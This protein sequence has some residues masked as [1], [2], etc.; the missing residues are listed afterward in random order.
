M[1]HFNAIVAGLAFAC[2]FAIDTGYA[3]T[4]AQ[5]KYTSGSGWSLSYYVSPREGLVVEDAMFSGL[6]VAKKMSVPYVVV[7]PLENIVNL[8]PATLNKG[9]LK[10]TTFGEMLVIEA[11]Y[12]VNPSI[13]IS[14]RYEFHAISKGCEPTAKLSCGRFKPLL[15]YTYSGVVK[16]NEPVITSIQRLHLQPSNGSSSIVGVFHDCAIPG[17]I[18]GCN[19]K[20]VVPL[21]KNPLESEAWFPMISRGRAINTDYGLTAD[22]Y[23]HATEGTIG[24]PSLNWSLSDPYEPG[25][26]ECLHIHWRWGSTAGSIA[27]PPFQDPIG[28]PIIPSGSDQSASIYIVKDT[29]QAVADIPSLVNGQ[30]L[31]GSMPV[32]FYKATGYQK[33]D[34]FF[35]HGGFITTGTGISPG[36]TEAPAAPTIRIITPQ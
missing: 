9:S 10:E 7:H 15:K 35:F 12:S 19:L 6:P 20:G 28:Q 23:H 17:E 31:S 4:N 22:N 16:P 8:T 2:T 21:G 5:K 32:L 25:C 29:G 1:R 27:K 34:T 26:A 24:T 30:S 33:T 14:Q 18:L 13:K 3:Q 11:E 36:P